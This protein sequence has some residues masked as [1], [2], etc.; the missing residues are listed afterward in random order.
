MQTFFNGHLLTYLG[1][2]GENSGKTRNQYFS[3]HY[4]SLQWVDYINRYLMP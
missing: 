2:R 1:G 3:T 4:C